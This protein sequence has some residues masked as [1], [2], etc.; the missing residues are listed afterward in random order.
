MNV[1]WSY[2]LELLMRPIPLPFSAASRKRLRL[3]LWA[4]LVAIG[5]AFASAIYFTSVYEMRPAGFAVPAALYICL[6]TLVWWGLMTFSL[7]AAYRSR[8]GWHLATAI[9]FASDL[10]VSILGIARER[11]H[12]VVP[13]AAVVAAGVAIVAGVFATGHGSRSARRSLAWSGR[14]PADRRAA[15]DVREASRYAMNSRRLSDEEKKTAR[16]NDARAA[17]VQSRGGDAPDGLVKAAA[18]LRALLDDPPDDWLRLFGAAADLVDAM[19]VRASKHGDIDGY[20]EALGLLAD[21]AQRTPADLGAMAVVHAR[22]AD[23]HVAMADRLP[24]DSAAHAHAAEAIANMRAAVGT[25]S[26]SLRPLLPEW[27]AKLGMFVARLRADPGDLQVGIEYCRQA[28]RLAGPWPR[29]RAVPKLALAVLLIDLATETADGLFPD[30][31]EA[32][33]AA[34]A[35]TAHQALTEAERYLR[36]AR[37]HSGFDLRAEILDQEARA[38]TTRAMIM[39]NHPLAD[40]RAARAW[41]AAAQASADGDPLDRVQVGRDWVS[42]AVTTE[43]ADW[44]AEAYWYLMSA[45]PPAVA[46][47]YLSEERDRVLRD[48]QATAEEAGYWLAEAGRIGDAAIALELGR[49]VSLS[50]VLAREQPDLPAALLSAGR[51]DLLAR[52]LAALSKRNAATASTVDENLSSARQRAWAAYDTVVREIATV[53]DVDPSGAPPTLDELMTA[54]CDGPLVFLA[55]T[56]QGGYAIVVSAEAAPVYRPLAG[57]ARGDVAERAESFLRGAG[58]DEIAAVARWLWDGGIRAVARELPSDALVTIIP[59]GLLTLLPVHVA[60]GPTAAM[61]DPADWTYLADRVTIRYAP[62]ART[63]IRARDRAARFPSEE[64]ALLAVTAPAGE[65]AAP[66]SG[67]GEPL[68]YAVREVRQIARWWVRADTVVDAAAARVENMLAGHTVWHFACHCL[69]TPERILDSSLLL[70]DGRLSLRRLLELPSVPR[71]LAVLSACETHL[72]DSQLPDEAM[73]LPA[74]LLQAGF[75]GTVACHWRVLDRPTAYLMIRFHELWQGQGHTP[76]VALAEAGRWLR[77]ATSAELA[78]CLDGVPGNHDAT[79]R[80]LAK[81]SSTAPTR[82]RAV[83][84]YGHPY[85]WAA[86]ALTGQ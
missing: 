32:E 11:W 59:V 69:V 17:I 1:T 58:P 64:L 18:D 15:Q 53:V 57:L 52:F 67:S 73:G 3:L 82:D 21:A 50:E 14:R 74:G 33:W 35:R 71:R 47:R 34:T 60:G 43:Q 36:Y 76:A 44:C 65:P 37:R 6:S 39:G 63:L 78:A 27:H 30:A 66:G 49:A 62:N 81:E 56:A 86:F 85:F 20:A 7:S 5:L 29:A 79:C 41:R 2:Y 61:Q 45:V 10:G 68:R 40:Y 19:S 13:A 70:A 84:K 38:R 24:P 77:T 25:A 54:A 16:L 22:R 75:A 31:S 23:Y 9:I 28:I 80:G 26:A 51:K 8:P 46:V 48:L 42:W 4:I 83:G 12:L 55:A 72:S